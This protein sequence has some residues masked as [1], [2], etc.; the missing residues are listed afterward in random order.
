MKFVKKHLFSIISI[1]IILIMVSVG[2]YFVYTLFYDMVSDPYENR[3]NGIEK[4]KISN[5]TIDGIKGEILDTDKVETVKYN[6]EGRL[7]NFIINVKKDTDLK[8]A[9]ELAKII[10]EGFNDNQKKFYDIQIYL[11]NSE[12]EK[13]ADEKRAELDKDSEEVIKTIYPVLGYLHKSSE[14]FVWTK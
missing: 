1:C 12:E 3:L 10:E 6:L 4:V 8:T 9:K 2:A 7:A 14:N 11:I 13:E 5:A